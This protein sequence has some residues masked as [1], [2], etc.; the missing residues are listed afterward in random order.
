MSSAQAFKSQVAPFKRYIVNPTVTDP[1]QTGRIYDAAGANG[2]SVAS[3]VVLRD[4]GKTVYRANGTP[5]R[6]VQVLPIDGT[7][8]SLPLEY[9]TGYIYLENVPAAQN[10]VALN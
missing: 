2:V 7:T 1:V 5:L 4:M 9:Q 3:D 6:K 8:S 10:I